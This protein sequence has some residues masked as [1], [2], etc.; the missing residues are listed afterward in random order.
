MANAHGNQSRRFRLSCQ[1]LTNTPRREHI[2]TP[3]EQSHVIHTAPHNQYSRYGH[4]IKP[5]PLEPTHPL[6]LLLILYM[7]T[8]PL[9]LTQFNAETNPNIR[10]L[11]NTPKKHTKKNHPITCLLT[12]AFCITIPD[13]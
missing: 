4:R 12:S 11:K 8:S 13:L 7:I 1:I 2:G 9:L 5:H 3:K 6:P 10:F